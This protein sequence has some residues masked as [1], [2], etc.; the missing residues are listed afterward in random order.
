MPSKS[1]GKTWSMKPNFHEE[2]VEA[3]GHCSTTFEFNHNDTDNGATRTWD[4]RIMGNF[5]CPNQSCT[6]QGWGSKII[7]ITIRLYPRNKYNA[8]VWHQRCRKCNTLGVPSVRE[9]YVERVSVRLKVWSGVRFE[10]TH[11]MKKKK[12]P[13]HEKSLCEGCKAGRCRQSLEDSSDEE[14]D[15]DDDLASALGGLGI[16]G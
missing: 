14:D 9:S 13:P 5:T 12:G 8:R 16:G 11:Q 10:R 4:T 6:S 15:D 1:K 2:V 7:P 3:V